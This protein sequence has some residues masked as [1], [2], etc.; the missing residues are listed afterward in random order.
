MLVSSFLSSTSTQTQNL[1]LMQ[2]SNEREQTILIICCRKKQ[3]DISFSSVCPVIENEFCHNIVK[4]VCGSTQLS[5]HGPTGT[6]TMLLYN[7]T[8]DQ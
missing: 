1:K 6:V 3:L 8:H 7:R 5:P 2:S 4:V